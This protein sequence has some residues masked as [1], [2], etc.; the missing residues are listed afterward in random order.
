M[1]FS[2]FLT[3]VAAFVASFYIVEQKYDPD[4]QLSIMEAG[5]LPPWVQIKVEIPAPPLLS[6]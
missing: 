5:L 1:N 3:Q 6:V 4:M 2:S